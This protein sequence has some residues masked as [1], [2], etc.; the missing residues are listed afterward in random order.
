MTKHAQTYP[1]AYARFNVGDLVVTKRSDQHEPFYVEGYRSAWKIVHRD[2]RY[3]KAYRAQFVCW[4]SKRRKE[5]S[6]ELAFTD[7]ELS[8]PTE[9]ELKEILASVMLE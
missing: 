3:N 9:A 7:G 1:K 8:P 4:L 2:L 6:K 5:L